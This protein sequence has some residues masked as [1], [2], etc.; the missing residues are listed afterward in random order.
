M[1]T[2]LR[3]LAHSSSR[4]FRH[5]P[6]AYYLLNLRSVLVYKSFLKDFIISF[7]LDLSNDYPRSVLLRTRHSTLSLYATDHGDMMT[8]NEIFV[9]RCYPYKSSLNDIILDIGSN[10]GISTAYFLS[11]NP[12][13][14][15]IHYEPNRELSQSQ[16]LNL[17]S[18]PSHRFSTCT[19]AIGPTSGTGTLQQSSHSRYNS[20]DLLP[21]TGING[22]IE[23]KSL[24]AV[25]LDAHQTYG[26]CDI[27]KIDIEG[28]GF[29][30]L[31]SIP[32]NFPVLPRII[33]IEEAQDPTLSLRWL[34]A[35]YKHS[36][37]ASGIHVYT[38]KS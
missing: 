33:Y 7:V 31:D 12:N 14:K 10:T 18:F 19:V 37:H 15:V 17:D 20:I 1:R 16:Q 35:N 26:S 34:R 3:Q 8:I 5:R 9:W 4:I 29:V 38:L 28:L 25:I 32:L 30:S 6:F 22:N 23:V 11:N 21:S 27:L 2:L 36:T 24:E 13:S